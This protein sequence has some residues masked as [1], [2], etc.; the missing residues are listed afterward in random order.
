MLITNKANNP[1]NIFFVFIFG[2]LAFL[3]SMDG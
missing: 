2:S 3:G 1:V